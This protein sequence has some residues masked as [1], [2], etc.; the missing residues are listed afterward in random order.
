[1]GDVPA[2]LSFTGAATGAGYTNQWFESNDNIVYNPIA[3]AFG[4]AYAPDAPTTTKY[5]KL[6]TTYNNG[7]TT[8]TVTST[9]SGGY[10]NCYSK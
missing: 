4:T 9:G 8:C 3:G 6:Q 2:P 10:C 7:A 1:M 5:Y